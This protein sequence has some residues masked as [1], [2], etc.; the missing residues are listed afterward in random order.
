MAIEVRKVILEGVSDASGL[1]ALIDEGVFQADEVIAVIGKTE[2]NGGVNDF[3]RILA[4][5]AFRKVLMDNGTRPADEVKQIPMVWSG[6]VDGVFCIPPKDVACAARIS[7]IF[8]KERQHRLNDTRV[9]TCRSL[10]VHVDGCLDHSSQ[11]MEGPETAR[12]LEPAARGRSPP[13][14]ARSRG[15]GSDMGAPCPGAA[16]PDPG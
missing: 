5:Q 15:A 4:D 16:G 2:G 1:A 9:H 14:S 7:I 11:T 13:G 10:V 8:R 3:T 12:Y 6:G